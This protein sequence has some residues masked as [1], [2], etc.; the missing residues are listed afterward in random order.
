MSISK[1]TANNLITALTDE[2]G[3]PD[4]DITL[5]RNTGAMP[6]EL[7]LGFRLV[8]QASA[9]VHEYQGGTLARAPGAPESVFDIETYANMEHS[10]PKACRSLCRRHSSDEEARSPS[11]SRA[12]NHDCGANN[13]FSSNLQFAR[14][15]GLNQPDTDGGSGN[16]RCH[17]PVDGGGSCKPR[18]PPSPEESLAS[19][20]SS[21]S[22]ASGAPLFT[23]SQKQANSQPREGAEPAHAQPIEEKGCGQPSSAAASGLPSL[24]FDYS[25]DEEL[26]RGRDETAPATSEANSISFPGENQ[27]LKGKRKAGEDKQSTPAKYSILDSPFGGLLRRLQK[28]G[29]EEVMRSFK[30]CSGDYFKADTAVLGSA[31]TNLPHCRLKKQSAA[32]TDGS[33]LWAADSAARWGEPNKNFLLQVMPLESLSPEKIQAITD[34][35]QQ[36]G[37][38]KITNLETD[39]EFRLHKP[40]TGD[41]P[42]AR[43]TPTG[44]G[45]KQFEVRNIFLP[46]LLVRFLQT[47]ADDEQQGATARHFRFLQSK[48]ILLTAEG[49]GRNVYKTDHELHRSVNRRFVQRFFVEA[50]ALADDEALNTLAASMGM[51]LLVDAAAPGGCLFKER[52]NQAGAGYDTKAVKMFVAT[53]ESKLLKINVSLGLPPCTPWA[54][55]DK[56][57]KTSTMGELKAVVDFEP[58]Q[59]QQAEAAKVSGM[60]VALLTLEGGHQNLLIANKEELAR[61]SALTEQRKK[62][63]ASRMKVLHLTNSNSSRQLQLHEEN[64]SAAAVAS[65]QV[66]LLRGRPEVIK[67]TTKA[68]DM[69]AKQRRQKT[70]TALTTSSAAAAEGPAAVEA[71]DGAAAVHCEDFF[72]WFAGAVDRE[73]ADLNI[74]LYIRSGAVFHEEDE[75]ASHL[76]TYEEAVARAMVEASYAVPREVSAAEGQKK[77]AAA[78]ERKAS[79]LREAEKEYL[80][81]KRGEPVTKIAGLAVDGFVI[82]SALAA[83]HAT[84]RHFLAKPATVKRMVGLDNTQLDYPKWLQQLLQVAK[85]CVPFSVT[86]RVFEQ[87]LAAMED[88]I[89]GPAGVRAKFFKLCTTAQKSTLRRLYEE[90]FSRIQSAPDAESLRKTIEKPVLF[91]TL[92]AKASVVSDV[93]KVRLVFSEALPE[94]HLD[95]IVGKEV[96]SKQMKTDAARNAVAAGGIPGI[97]LLTTEM[98]R[99]D[100]AAFLLSQSCNLGSRT[101]SQEAGQ[102]AHDHLEQCFIFKASA[103][104]QAMFDTMGPRLTMV[105]YREIGAHPVVALRELLRLATR[106]L[107]FTAEGWHLEVKRCFYSLQGTNSA[108]SVGSMLLTPFLLAVRGFLR[109]CYDDDTAEMKSTAELQ[110]AAEDFT[111]EMDEVANIIRRDDYS[112][113]DDGRLKLIWNAIRRQLEKYAQTLEMFVALK[114]CECMVIGTSTSAGA[115]ASALLSAA[116]EQQIA[117]F[118]QLFGRQIKLQKQIKLFGYP[119]SNISGG[120]AESRALNNAIRMGIFFAEAILGRHACFGLSEEEAE[121]RRKVLQSSATPVPEKLIGNAVFHEDECNDD[122]AEWTIFPL[123]AATVGL[124]RRDE[125]ESIAFSAVLPDENQICSGHVL[126]STKKTAAIAL[127]AVSAASVSERPSIGVKVDC[128]WERATVAHHLLRD[129]ECALKFIPNGGRSADPPR[130]RATHVTDV[131]YYSPAA[132]EKGKG[133]LDEDGELSGEGNEGDGWQDELREFLAEAED[134]RSMKK[135]REDLKHILAGDVGSAGAG[136][137]V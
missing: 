88:E 93:G 97:S 60:E 44:S 134:A 65:D 102:Q 122:D 117:E 12:A 46:R 36:R 2:L 54:P 110:S 42:L 120:A 35:F 13:G 128:C 84:T 119:I 9:F 58:S 95:R 1:G 39:P 70:P 81:L 32:E 57:R 82:P 118:T 87:E 73:N 137:A 28:A 132:W 55:P 38:T 33:C 63:S 86:P 121:D 43:A 133:G 115:N 8:A 25:S 126:A 124:R 51:T 91:G 56:Q 116:E 52:N 125:D 107:F 104:F 23:P 61:I 3:C 92:L 10:R 21:G 96:Q 109:N 123:A 30:L 108:M 68:N 67:G 100:Q 105:S 131:K 135:L 7:Q 49:S 78:K 50:N 11:A 19:S 94:R 66:E 90:Q 64:H 24:M 71:G 62:A 20:Q 76:L 72:A 79:C 4:G 26:L 113:E 59:E 101:G 45:P 18:I 37:G 41:K 40:A 16:R 111:K 29:V 89:Q 112:L 14:N 53:A 99:K 98:R 114:K 6:S 74:S 106:A 27:L 31:K 85:Q 129:T 77:R 34:F 5:P 130:C 69:Q 80:G 75:A 15:S 136:D 127:A 83:L 17:T 47:G 103:D 48:D 22:S